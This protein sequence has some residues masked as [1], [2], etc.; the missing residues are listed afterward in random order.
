[1]PCPDMDAGPFEMYCM[2]FPLASPSL[3][4]W[5]HWDERCCHMM[6]RFIFLIDHPVQVAFVEKYVKG[7]IPRQGAIFSVSQTGHGPSSCWHNMRRSWRWFGKVGRESTGALLS[8]REK[9]HLACE[10]AVFEAKRFAFPFL[11]HYTFYNKWTSTSVAT[12][13]HEHKTA[14]T[15]NAVEIC[16]RARHSATTR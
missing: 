12:S 6:G 9:Q 4:C 7:G 10:R 16:W 8:R 15:R 11:G 3:K 2:V 13:V 1:M 14:L 5:I